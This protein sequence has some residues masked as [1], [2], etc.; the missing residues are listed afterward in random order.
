MVMIRRF[1]A[2]SACAAAFSMLATPAAALD[3]PQPARASAYGGAVVYEG[4]LAENRRWRRHRH[5][6]GIDAGDV[7]AG[8]LILGTIAAVAGAANRNREAERRAPPPY[9]AEPY[10]YRPGG[11]D[12]DGRGLD[13][14]VDMC[15]DEI[16]RGPDRVGAVAGANRTGEGWSVSG[17]L[18]DGAGFTC[19]IDNAGRI[20]G[21]DIG[22]ARGA[23]EPAADSRY[24][25]DVYARAR[26]ERGAAE[27]GVAPADGEDDRPVW[28]G[29]NPA[30]APEGDGRYDVSQ[31]P[32]FEQG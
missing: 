31:T 22:G 30:G 1:T 2:A 26:I 6:D 27:P 10:R 29:D 5:R 18:E 4:D 15:V 7:I 25:D 12:S 17:A 24:S 16:E 28:T 13:R 20:R 32:D 8:V 14:A 3:L 19:R 21:I 23:Y 9:P 11:Y